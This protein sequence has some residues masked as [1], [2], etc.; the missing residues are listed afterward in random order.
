VNESRRTGLLRLR[1]LHEVTEARGEEM[2]ELRGRFQ[3]LAHED[4]APRVVSAFNLF[5]TPEPI[6][7]MMAARF[8]RFGRTLEPSAGLGRLYRAIRRRD[9]AAPV[10]LVDNSP[11]CCRELYAATIGDEW[12]VLL[13]GDFLEMDAA[14]LGG[15]FDS[16][17]MNPPF[18]VGRDCK[19][20]LH[21]LDLLAPGGRLVALCAAG[22]RQREKLEPIADSFEE[23][24]ARSFASEGTNVNAAMVIFNR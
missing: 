7:D 14:R 2:A 4:A 1:H 17:V 24:P 23:L 3:R 6:A 13:Q 21:A 11:E 22:P 18:K 19:H 16:I 12:A 15:P 10:V 8:E 9:P 5:Q 20:I